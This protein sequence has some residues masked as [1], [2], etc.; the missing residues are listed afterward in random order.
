M[1]ALIETVIEN[2]EMV[3]PNHANML[4]VA[5]GGNVMKWMDEVG[6]M[7]AMR[8][9]GETCVTAHVNRMDFERPIPVGDTAYITAYVYDAG[10]SSVKVRLV[11]ER[12]DLRTR[13]REKTTE[14]YFVYVAIDEDNEPTPVPELT[15]SSEQEN[16]LRQQALAGENGD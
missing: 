4:D 7:S 15:V 1:T 5:H 8:F 14:S 16:Q 9:A 2:R 6:A 11:T 12:E 3:Q 13:E 10:T